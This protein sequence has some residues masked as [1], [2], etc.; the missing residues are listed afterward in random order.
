MAAP[1]HFPEANAVLVGSP[2]DKAAGI[3]LD[4]PTHRYQD[5]DGNRHVISCWRFTPEELAE[6]A[7]TGCAWLHS[8]GH[9]HPPV[10]I[11]GTTPFVGGGDA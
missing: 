9:T 10:S 4:L 2:E 8:W 5:L 11:G 6:I 7:R 1:I 3:V